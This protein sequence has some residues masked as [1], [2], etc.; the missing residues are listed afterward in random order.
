MEHDDGNDFEFDEEK[1]D[2]AVEHHRL[3]PNA[4]RIVLF[5]LDRHEKGNH[6]V[7]PRP[8]LMEVAGIRTPGA[9]SK[10][11]ELTRDILRREKM[12]IVNVWGD[13]YAIAHTPEQS[14][15]EVMKS[16]F[17]GLSHLQSANKRNEIFEKWYSVGLPAQVQRLYGRFEGML[18]QL[19]AFA[20][21]ALP[22]AKALMKSIDGLEGADEEVTGIPD[23]LLRKEE[24]WDVDEAASRLK[25]RLK[26][27]R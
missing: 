8:D 24:E 21:K 3:Y 27:G 10:V 17:R 12:D 15:K 4:K 9:W 1:F 22:V 19:D 11:H 6:A 23:K 16:F 13:G 2:E 26:K 20:K 14:A 7:V 25:D 18:G 5:L